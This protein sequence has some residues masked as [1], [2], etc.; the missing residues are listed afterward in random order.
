MKKIQGELIGKIKRGYS[1]VFILLLILFTFVSCGET[2]VNNSDIAGNIEYCENPYK[3]GEINKSTLKLK[4]VVISDDMKTVSS[5]MAGIVDT[6]NCNA[7]KKVTSNTL[8]AK[9]SP[10]FNNP[11]TINLSI[12]KGSLINQ[13]INLESI[14]SST[15]S[16][17][18]NQI[19]DLKEQ[20]LI[21]EK[22]IE[23]TK[24]SSGLNK[25]D[26]EKQIISS[27]T[28]LTSLESNLI[29][30][31]KSKIEALEKIDISGVSLFTSM[32]SLSGDNLLKIDE[33]YGITED[34]KDLNDKY[35]DYLSAKD[36]SLG[37]AVE[38]EFIRLNNIFKN[39][40]D[41][42]DSEISDF[43]GDLVVLDEMARD[44]VKESIANV[45]FS[46]TQIDGLYLLFLTYS[47]SLAEIKS[48]WDSLENSI[49]STITTFDTQILSLQ[50][51][52]DTTKTSLENL[53][54]NKLDSIDVGLD[55]QLSTFD[56]ALKTLN[57][58]LSN[59]LST[60]ESQVLSLD[61]Q[62]LQVNQSIDS[63]NTNLSVRNI[64]AN[65]SGIIKQKSSSTGNSV[66]INTSICQI[67]PNTQS[68]KVKIYSPI[69]LNMGDKLVFEFNN[70]SYEIMIENVLVYKDSITQNYV[71]ESNYL[72]E[73]S[74]KDGEILSLKIENLFLVTQSEEG[75]KSKNIKIPVSYVINK[76]NGNFVKINS[77]LGTLEKEIILGDINGNFIEI[78]SGLE[79]VS[80]ICK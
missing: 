9:I 21:T 30:A 17:F 62:I 57:S 55:L 15:I 67:S 51:Q 69:E 63:L 60:K 74:F 58:S 11:N 72:N 61:N 2:E 40:N 54:T 20:I 13:K 71:Y 23:L 47:N 28:T 24:K 53:Q 44:A 45:N 77:T 34:N 80:E 36:S 68:K 32:N 14:K 1:G 38:L 76:I 56:S 4:G 66:G 18:D 25:N 42:S 3:I 37:N 12:Q 59:L 27:E 29:L 73:N 7:G 43:L 19:S 64:Y 31:E 16:S 5:P 35:E 50:N 75:E 6:L 33:T 65:V 79:N 78:K 70:Q 52:I 26:L 49:S 10:D 41:L 48:G 39:I 46:Q 22:N 8:I